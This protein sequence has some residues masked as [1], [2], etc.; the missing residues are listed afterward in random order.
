M[1]VLVITITHDCSKE[2]V[3]FLRHYC[4]FADQ[5]WAWDDGSMD[6]TTEILS[7]TPKVAL[8]PWPHFGSGIGE[9]LF[10]D[11]AYEQYPKARGRFDW[12]IWVDPDEFVYHPNIRQL[13]QDSMGKYDVI[14]A[15]G[16]NMTGQGFPPDDGRQIWEI[17]TSGIRAPIYSKPVVFNP[18]CE[19]RWDRGKHHL[20]K[21]NIRATEHSELKLL[22]YR[23]LGADY[24][25]LKNAK[26]YSRCGMR[27]NDRGAAWS[28]APN[29]D[30]T[31]KEH[32]PMW[33]DFVQAASFNAIEAQL[34]D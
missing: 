10:L 8:F 17:L 28:C 23:Y 24:T 20:E 34:Y 18:N 32:S 6:G 7:S 29:F 31:D 30:G 14:R 4:S 27:T 1:K 5:I 22:H 15:A 3:F 16:F 25:R 26:N 2:I 21:C 19:I 9:N 13:L 33:A 12:V 11:F